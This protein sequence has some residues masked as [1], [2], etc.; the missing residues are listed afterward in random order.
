MA[1]QDL[2]EADRGL[3]L[4]LPVGA[5]LGVAAAQRLHQALG[6]LLDIVLQVG[7]GPQRHLVDGEFAGIG[8]AHRD[9]IDQGGG[10]LDLGRVDL[11]R[12]GDVLV[13]AL[14]QD[15]AD[16]AGHALDFRL[17]RVGDVDA[18]RRQLAAPRGIV[19]Q[20]E[21]GAQAA[22]AVMQDLQLLADIV[23]LAAPDVGAQAGREEREI[24]QRDRDG[25]AV[26]RGGDANFIVGRRHLD[27]QDG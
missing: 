25:D 6:G 26:G 23:E 4:R 10:L 1:E 8:A 16:P 19:A 11:R 20:V 7:I 18:D 21:F 9:E 17:Q 24:V 22:H 12:G 13:G 15:A 27:R 3:D 2:A 14:A 5:R